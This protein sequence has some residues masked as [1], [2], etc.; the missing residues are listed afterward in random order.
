MKD[1]VDEVFE[2]V[3]SVFDLAHHWKE[4]P[5]VLLFEGVFQ[6]SLEE[7]GLHQG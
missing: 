4:E 3:V 6:Q 2:V 1:F 7:A 5:G